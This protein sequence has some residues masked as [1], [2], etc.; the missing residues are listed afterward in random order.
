MTINRYQAIA[1]N[2]DKTSTTRVSSN[3]IIEYVDRIAA[4]FKPQRI[5]LFGS[6]ACGNPTQESDVDLLITRKR[7]SMSPLTAAGKIRVALGVPFPMDL[8]VRSET[9]IQRWI[10]GGDGFLREILET[11]ITLYA[12]D[13]ARVGRQGRIRLRRRL[14]GTALSQKSRRDRICFF[15]Q[16]CVEKYLKARLT[17]AGIAFPRTHELTILLRLCLPIEPRWQAFDR[18]LAAMTQFAVLVRYPGTWATLREAQRGIRTCRR[19][20]RRARRSLGL[21][22]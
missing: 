1:M 13:D 2:N 18:A 3:R 20:R 9:Q 11:G 5:V 15:S 14:R 7:W 6:Y 16:Q 10:A 17:E 22:P 19:F 4:A 8:I 21:R 12:A